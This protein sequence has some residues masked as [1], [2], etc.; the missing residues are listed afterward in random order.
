MPPPPEDCTNK[1]VREAV[2]RETYITL[3][4]ACTIVGAIVGGLVWLDNR[5]DDRDRVFVEKFSVIEQ[6]LAD[7]ERLADDRFTKT[8]ASE[9]ALRNAINNPGLRFADPRN[10]GAFF[11]V[12]RGRVEGAGAAE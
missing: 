3:G 1:S 12:E 8:Q 5:L 6:R 2:G 10:P 4:S 11:V 9:T 7:V